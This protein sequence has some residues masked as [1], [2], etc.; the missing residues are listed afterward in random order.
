MGLSFNGCPGSSVE[1]ETC[2][3]GA[4]PTWSDWSSWNDCSADCDGGTQSRSRECQNGEEGDCP[5]LAIDDQ[6]C[7]RLSCDASMVWWEETEGFGFYSDVLLE[8]LP[9]GETIFD[10]CVAYCLSYPGCIAASAVITTWD[11]SDYYYYYYY[12]GDE[13]RENC[14]IIANDREWL[15]PALLVNKREAPGFSYTGTFALRKDYY[16]SN[17]DKMFA[18]YRQ[19]DGTTGSSLV[20]IPGLCDKTNTGFGKVDYRNV[21]AV[22]FSN[23]DD[24][25]VIRDSDSSDCAA[26]C[27]ETAGCSSFFVDDNGCTYI[28]GR[29]YKMEEDDTVTNAGMLN[30][31][32]PTDAFTSTFTRRSRFYCL[33]WAPDVA[34]NIAGTIV[35]QNTGNSDTPL[36]VWS[37]E[38]ASNNPLIKSSQYVSVTQPDMQGDDPRYRPVIFSIETHVRIGEEQCGRRRRSADRESE[39]IFVGQLTEKI[40]KKFHKRAGKKAK[41]IGMERCIMP[42]NEDILAEIQAIEQQATSFILD[43]GMVMP[44]NVDVAATGPIETVEFVQSAA[45]GS[46]SADCSSGSCECSTGFIDNG[47]G[48]E[49]MTI[50]Q[51]ATTQAPTTQAPT[52]Q[53]PITTTTTTTESSA[54]GVTEFLESLISKVESI[55]EENRP[56][57]P[58]THL[59]KKWQAL[60][61]KFANRYKKMAVDKGCNFANSHNDDSINWDSVNTCK[62]RFILTVALSL[63]TL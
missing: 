17:Y 55:F 63:Y 37:F 48:C 60:E 47:N 51:A 56:G 6:Q 27:F 19:P 16:E 53:A 42:Q 41:K 13:Y 9:D 62:V 8:Y 21:G 4:C 33:I 43:G 45:D 31:L 61:T 5:G 30:N 28:I 3:D 1:T 7:N 39:T 25:N 34:E 35:Q 59:L 58:R 23:L 20:E 54:G 46:V 24:K 2:N 32:C 50:E 49:A 18:F 26:K 11:A 52:T 44:D 15:S 22:S 36:H 38:T 57:K 12:G 29:P 10:R 40:L 14:F